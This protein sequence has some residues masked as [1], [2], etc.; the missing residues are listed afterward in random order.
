MSNRFF[1]IHDPVGLRYLF[2]VRV[3][4][5][6]LRG[7]KWCHN[8]IDTP[9][10]IYH[11]GQGIEDTSHFLFSC[12]SYAAQ[13]VAFVTIVNEILNKVSLIHLENQSQLYLYGNPSM[14]ISDNKKIIL[15]TIKFIKETRRFST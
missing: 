12:P 2:Q 13:R 6:S 11:C 4:L 10:G 8:F 1:E 15:S 3:S 5:S 14:D 7:H 9:S